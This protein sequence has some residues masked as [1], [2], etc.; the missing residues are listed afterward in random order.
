MEQ[1][2]NADFHVTWMPLSE[3][4]SSKFNERDA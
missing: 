3:E 4:A 1:A 2:Q